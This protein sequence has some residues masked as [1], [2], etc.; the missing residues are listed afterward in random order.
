MATRADIRTQVDGLLGDDP[1]MSTAELNALIQLKYSHWYEAWHWSRR[2]R[3]FVM[4]T[5]GQVSSGTTDTVTATLGSPTIDSI[6]TPFTSTM[7]GAYIEIGDL[8]QYYVVA[9]VNTAQIT[10]E[11]GEGAAVNWPLATASGLSWRVFK[12]RYTLPAT[13]EALLSLAGDQEITELDGGRTS[14]DQMDPD[15]TT[16]GDHPK[17][18][19][20][21][22]EEAGVRTIELWPIPSEAR[23]FRGKFLRAAPTLADGTETGL[24]LSLMSYG[25]A[26]DAFN[27]LFAKTGD[28]AY[29]RLALFY[30]RKSL[31][32]D[33]D[34]K[35]LDLE[36][37]SPP[38]TLRRGPRGLGSD[39]HVT[40]L[41]EEP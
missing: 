3:D 10:L 36:R 35:P 9:Y 28:E 25:V 34:F 23:V 8:R 24:N 30:E 5:F 31:E 19:F 37:T 14:M 40:H 7:D 17:W 13:A 2:T 39:W 41:A 33:K 11:D 15:R 29:H 27:V 32:V 18:W 22:G 21:D 16:T 12:H 4:A 1:Q 20:Y 38:A 26:A 6:G